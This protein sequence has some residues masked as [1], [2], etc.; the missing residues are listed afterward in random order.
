MYY[1][2][3]TM[4]SSNQYIVY[5]ENPNK[6]LAEIKRR[7]TI[8]GGANVATKSLYTPRGIMTEV[9]DEDM[10]I[11]QTDFAFQQHQKNGF[12]TIEKKK[13]DPE[14]VAKA[15][16]KAEDESAPIT[17]D[18]PDVSGLYEKTENPNVMRAKERK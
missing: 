14:K 6:N 12:I 15:K 5:S 8:H 16:L 17:P 13:S 9:S 4:T 3:S 18:S 1:V 2:F 10:G 7:I 11:L